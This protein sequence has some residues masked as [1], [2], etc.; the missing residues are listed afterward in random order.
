MRDEETY[1]IRG[2]FRDGENRHTCGGNERCCYKAKAGGG[3]ISR[4]IR[5]GEGQ[6]EDSG[7]L[8]YALCDTNGMNGFAQNTHSLLYRIK[9]KH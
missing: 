9:R 4:E 6:G 7:P 8:I 2:V 5:R 3:I 1:H